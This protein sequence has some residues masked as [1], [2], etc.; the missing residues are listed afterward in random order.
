[1]FIL[2]QQSVYGK[3]HCVFF[4]ALIN[5]SVELIDSNLT[6]RIS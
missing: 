5:I 1:M 2:F 4:V 3:I 6:G